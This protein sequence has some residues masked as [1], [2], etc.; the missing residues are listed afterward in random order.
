MRSFAV[1][2]VKREVCT[3]DSEEVE[4]EVETACKLLRSVQDR[5]DMFK[6]RQTGV[7][8]YYILNALKGPTFL[9]MGMSNNGIR[10]LIVLSREADTCAK[11]S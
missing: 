9:T 4:E 8:I 2:A 3:A 6:R 10:V 7:P 11:P 1:T 5:E